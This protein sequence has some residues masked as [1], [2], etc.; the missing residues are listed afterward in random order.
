MGELVGTRVQVWW[1]AERAWFAG[2][3]KEFE[4]SDGSHLVQYDDTSVEWRVLNNFKWRVEGSKKARRQ[5]SRHVGG[6]TSTPSVAQR[7]RSTRS[8][9]P[10]QPMRRSKRSQA[11]RDAPAVPQREAKRKRSAAGPTP[12]EPLSTTMEAVADVTLPLGLMVDGGDDSSSSSD[13][14]EDEGLLA[15]ARLFDAEEKVDA[16]A[17]PR[18]VPELFP[19]KEEHREVDASAREASRTSL[20]AMLHTRQ[21]ELSTPAAAAVAAAEPP[22]LIVF[23]SGAGSSNSGSD[24]ESDAV[25]EGDDADAEEDENGSPLHVERGAGGAAAPAPLPPPTAADAPGSFFAQPQRQR[26]PQ[27]ARVPPAPRASTPQPWR[28]G[29]ATQSSASSSAAVPS[30]GA[31]VAPSAA[32]VQAAAAAAAATAAARRRTSMQQPLLSPLGPLSS[33]RA[34]R[35]RNS[36]IVGILKPT[37]ASFVP[38]KDALLLPKLF[39]CA[40]CLRYF[41]HAPPLRRAFFS[42]LRYL[43][44]LTLALSLPLPLGLARARAL[45][46]SGP[47]SRSLSLAPAKTT[48]FS[49]SFL[50][51]TRSPLAPH[52]SKSTSGS[53]GGGRSA[54]RASIAA[55][56]HGAAER[57]QSPFLSPPSTASSVASRVGSLHDHFTTIVA[58]PLRPHQVRSTSKDS[59]SVVGVDEYST[60]TL[61]RPIL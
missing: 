54:G 3:V 6:A 19:A 1:P 26:Q 22:V 52:V 9:T 48:R 57:H 37:S 59:P 30:A 4:A 11:S 47:R 15:Q 35:S 13:G 2:R 39:G 56:L 40:S 24:D 49:K 44:F 23:S 42:L 17:A 41:F 38:A 29:A 32:S 50:H 5:P 16:V 55:R 33:E 60:T 12:E 21:S 18:S 28:S 45:A 36:H 10:N 53:A 61:V 58:S 43:R 25:A 51:M 27:H 46:P 20:L 7:S 34:V 14:S 31:S 8:T